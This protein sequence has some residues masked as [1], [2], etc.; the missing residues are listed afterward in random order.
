MMAKVKTGVKIGLFRQMNGLL[1]NL[2]AFGFRRDS[3]D[4]QEVVS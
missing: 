1:A 2:S 4:D 3:V